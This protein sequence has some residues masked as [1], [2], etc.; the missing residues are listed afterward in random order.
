MNSHYFAQYLLNTGVFSADEVQ[1]LLA[2]AMEIQVQLPVLALRQGILSA[3]Q[4]APLAELSEA[5]FA[6]AALK[7]ALLTES[8]IR[9]LR[10]SVTGESL[11]FA[12]VLLSEKLL[13]YVRL[14]ELFSAYE[15]DGNPLRVAVAKVADGMLEEELG[16]YGDY[17]ELFMQSLLRF[18]NMPAVIDVQSMP[19]DAEMPA[20]IVSQRMGGDL[21][22]VGGIFAEDRV[23]AGLAARYSREDI[24]SV[25]DLAIDSLGEFLNVMNGLF[26]V[27]LAKRQVDIDLELPRWQKNVKPEANKMLELCIVTGIGS[28][29]L[30]LASDEFL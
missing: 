12:Q 27:K 30:V 20:H 13:D 29:M 4:I 15:Q 8:Q 17:V 22:L 2:K 19:L 16:A 28:F 5:D 18:M 11:R 9:N 7:K 10:E 1:R 23:F 3:G 24:K 21:N 25:D 6:K 26:A 14:A